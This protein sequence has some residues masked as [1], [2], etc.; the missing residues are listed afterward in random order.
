[1]ILIKR[2]DNSIIRKK[3]EEKNKPVIEFIIEKIN[4]ISLKENVNHTLFAACPNS[5]NVLIAALRSAKRA[6]AP[7]MFAATL[8]QVD[9]DRG[10]A[11]IGLRLRHH[12]D[13]Q[14]GIIQ[15]RV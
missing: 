13:Y 5:E 3:A 6:D 9:I 1:M 12:Q 4:D 7:V 10:H 14:A 2:I 8:N 15:D 11:G